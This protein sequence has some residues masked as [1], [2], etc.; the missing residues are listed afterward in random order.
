[1]RRATRELGRDEHRIQGSRSPIQRRYQ[2]NV[3]TQLPRTSLS[4]FRVPIRPWNWRL[5]PCR[6][7][8]MADSLVNL[9]LQDG[10][11]YVHVNILPALVLVA[12]D[13]AHIVVIA[14]TCVSFAWSLARTVS[15]VGAAWVFARAA[16]AV[17]AERFVWSR[18]VD[19]FVYDK[20]REY[21]D[22]GKR[23]R[24]FEATGAN[25][26]GSLFSP[27]SRGVSAREDPLA[28]RRAAA[29]VAAATATTHPVPRTPPSTSRSP[30]RLAHVSDDADQSTRGRLLASPRVS[31]GLRAASTPRGRRGLPL[32]ALRDGARVCVELRGGV[33][34]GGD[35][36]S[37]GFLCVHPH[38]TYETAGALGAL[39]WGG[40]QITAASRAAVAAMCRGEALVLRTADDGET[41]DAREDETSRRFV[42]MASPEAHESD[43][44]RF[45]FWLHLFGGGRDVTLRS[46][47]TGTLVTTFVSGVRFE[48]RRVV[49]WHKTRSSKLL[50]AGVS[51]FTPPEGGAWEEFALRPARRGPDGVAPA[52]DDAASCDEFAVCRPR[53]GTYWKYN[54][55]GDDMLAF[56]RDI[57]DATLVRLHDARDDGNAWA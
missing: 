45:A 14:V 52:E 46:E 51:M 17:A 31:S 37:D 30:S 48:R 27:P 40:H 23:R 8:V 53:E 42:T 49:A 29:A 34:G 7:V 25:N 26:G 32:G 50:T 28:E 20:A 1:M 24:L 16:A 18:V 12:R 41:P 19:P 47:A 15:I 35:G 55:G 13:V 22:I 6:A 36:W 33:G 21:V 2:S 57:A 10:I 39:H 3:G 43:A 9:G 54:G 56:T 5:I 11:Q 44:S 4:A 38:K